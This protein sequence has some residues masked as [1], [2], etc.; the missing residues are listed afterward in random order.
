MMKSADHVPTMSHGLLRVTYHSQHHAACIKEPPQ[1]LSRY[2]LSHTNP[3]SNPG[4]SE[5]HTHH[6]PAGWDVIRTALA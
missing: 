1:A 6:Q 4:W 2:M 3:V 5:K